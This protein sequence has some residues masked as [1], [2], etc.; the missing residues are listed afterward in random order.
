MKVTGLK[1][2]AI[3]TALTLEQ[4]RKLFHDGY[5]VLKGAVSDHLVDAALAR[6]KASRKGE[7]L[8][9]AKELTDLVNASTVTPILTE[10]MGRF[11]PPSLCHVGITKQSGPR[12]YFTPLGYRE[13]DMP[14]FGYSLHAEGLF[15]VSPP[16]EPAEGTEVSNAK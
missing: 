2:K 15:T 16:Q 6:I 5:I 10:A 8:T 4:K 13:K 11:D 9:L 3:A 1:T 14:Y 7:S 12:E